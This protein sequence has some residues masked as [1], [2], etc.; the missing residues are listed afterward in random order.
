MDI[1]IYPKKLFG[2]INAIA[3]KSH[4]HRLLIC[5]AFSD[6]PTELILGE[7]NED[8][9]ATIQCLI[10][11]GAEISK[12]EAG[13][14]V[15]PTTRIPNEATLNCKESGSTLRFML[16]VVGALGVTTTFQTAGRLSQRPLSPLHEEMERMGCLIT[17]P[18]PTTIRCQGKLRPGPYHMDGGVSSQ[19]ITGILFACSLMHGESAVQ[20]HGKLESAPYVDLTW[21]VL[22]TFGI[23]SGNLGIAKLKSP[24][25]VVVE[26]DWS[27]AAFFLAANA[28]GSKIDVTNLNPLSAQ[29]DKICAQVFKDSHSPVQLDCS[30][31]P[32][33]VP[34]LSVYAAATNGGEF[35]GIKRLR[36]KESDRIASTCAMLRAMGIHVTADN[37]KMTV[38]PGKIHGGIVD[39]CNDHRI[40]MA[41]AIAAIAACSPVTI[42][43]AECVSKSYPTFWEDYK[44]LGGNY[45]QHLR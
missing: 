18:S 32:D 13:Y 37:N 43:G 23:T 42:V 17:R 41:A 27:N 22:N 25:S 4:A 3:S 5:A 21:Q 40:A 8:I 6:A 11:L 14:L 1:T 33:L 45:E 34:I 19:F 10:A 26:G 30:D 31:I 39:S 20:I 44:L 35:T 16:P 29:G 28:L 12:T 2:H 15:Q 24:G 9:Q 36:L 7:S 38:L